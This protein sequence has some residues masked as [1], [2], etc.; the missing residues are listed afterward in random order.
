M[1]V[2]FK[3]RDVWKP[4][5]KSTGANRPASN[6]ILIV[7]PFWDGDKAQHV[8]LARLIA[9]LEAQHCELA[10]ILF[11]ARFDADPDQDTV[12]YVSRKFNVHIYKCKRR[13]TGWPHGCNG[14]NAGAIEFFYNMSRS[15]K[16]P[17]YKALLLCEADCV[18][19]SKTWIRDLSQEWDRVSRE[20]YVCIAGAFIPNAGARDHINGGCAFLSGDIAFIGW[21]ATRLGRMSAGWDWEL[22]PQFKVRGWADIPAIWSHWRCPDKTEEE[23]RQLIRTGVLLFHGCKFFGMLENARKIL[24]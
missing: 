16:I 10:D 5:H 3:R 12:K 15:G 2:V 24:L 9:D 19:L 11:L 23:V 14:L 22:A 1:P 6:K 4:G 18:P 13:E 17:G 20:K 8:A 7:L 21:L